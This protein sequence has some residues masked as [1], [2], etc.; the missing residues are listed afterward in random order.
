MEFLRVYPVYVYIYKYKFAL[1]R[2][3]F[4]T[5]HYMLHFYIHFV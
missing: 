2:L 3:Q 4:K 1:K 5:Y